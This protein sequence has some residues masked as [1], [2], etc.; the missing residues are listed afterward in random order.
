MPEK[1]KRKT[2]GGMKDAKAEV[3]KSKLQEEKFED[4][5]GDESSAEDELMSDYSGDSDGSDEEE[6]LEQEY[7]Q[8]SKD[9]NKV[10]F[11]KVQLSE[12]EA[13]RREE[14]LKALQETKKLTG[15]AKEQDTTGAT[16]TEV[17]DAVLKGTLFLPLRFS[18]YGN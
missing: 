13:R 6:E 18:F 3:K 10:V 16:I 17:S 8:K 4:E 1:K 7:E 5:N 15:T 2:E 11:F 14:N 9:T 12:E